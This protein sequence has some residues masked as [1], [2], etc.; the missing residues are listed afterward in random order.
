M[1]QS[2]GSLEQIFEAHVQT[3]ALTLRRDT[4]TNYR[5]VVH[6]FLGYLQTAFPKVRRPAQLRRDPH[7]RGWFRWMCEQNPPLC[8]NRPATG[9]HRHSRKMTKDWPAKS[10]TAFS[11][12][13]QY[14]GN[15][16]LH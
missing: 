2:K 11:Q 12:A 5:C 8:N 6:R 3:L 10:R 7:L 14:L 16:V 1:S 9:S 13:E 15:S 4:V